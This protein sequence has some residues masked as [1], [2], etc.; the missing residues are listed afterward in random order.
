MIAR[1]DWARFEKVLRPKLAG[2]ANLAAATEGAALDFL[3]LFSA[4]ASWLGNPGQSNYAA[5]N[6]TLDA[7]AQSLAARGRAATSIVWGRWAGGGMAAGGTARDWNAAGVGEIAVPEGVDAMFAL[8]GSGRPVAAILPLDWPRYL[9]GVYGERPPR[10]FAEVLRAPEAAAKQGQGSA[11]VAQLLAVPA[12]QRRAALVARLEAIVRRVVGVPAERRIDP[13]LPVRDL[14][15]DSLMTVDLRNAIAR[16]FDRALPATLVFD[17]PTL[18][19][20]ADYLAGLVPE[21]GPSGEPAAAPDA[22]AAEVH[23]MSEAEAEAE[24]L[25][26]LQ[27]EALP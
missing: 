4:G 14:G 18:D 2:A 12:N 9:A 15:M 25:R 17:H 5:A 20:L 6:A 1:Q 8:A 13:A 21:L 26:E 16:A 24:L 23:A 7:L 3:V 11:L 27:Q 19:A 10:L 22:A